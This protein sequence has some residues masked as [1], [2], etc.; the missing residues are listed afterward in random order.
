[1]GGSTALITYDLEKKFK[2]CFVDSPAVDVYGTLFYNAVFNYLGGSTFLASI[3]MSAEHFV[4]R[5]KSSYGF[6]PF[7][8][9][10]LKSCASIGSRPLF[11]QQAFGDI[12]VPE[13]NA[14]KCLLAARSTGG[15]PEYYF[16][17]TG[18]YKDLKIGV[19]DNHCKL[20]VADVL[21]F[22]NRLVGFFDKYLK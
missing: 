15:N 21:G 11:I 6:P 5:S 1:M 17:D 3:I 10:P 13:F 7:K 18:V 8:F 16:G 12:V 4:S 9:D 19:C 22:R 2:A 20:S 14:N